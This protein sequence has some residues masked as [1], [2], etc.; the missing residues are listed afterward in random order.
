M[1]ESYGNFNVIR[2][3]LAKTGITEIL[4]YEGLTEVAINQPG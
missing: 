3:Q 4:G 2:N 1:N